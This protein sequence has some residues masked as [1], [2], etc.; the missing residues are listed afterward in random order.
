MGA[1]LSIVSGAIKLFNFIASALQQHHDEMNGRI[2]QNA[3]NQAASLKADQD[4]EIISERNAS[5]DRQ[6]LASKLHE[7]TG[8]SP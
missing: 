2:A 3:D 6:S 7:Q 5:L 1:Y 8:V 4:A